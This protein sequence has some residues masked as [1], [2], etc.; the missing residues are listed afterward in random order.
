MKIPRMVKPENEII[1][2]E[3]ITTSDNNK[4]LILTNMNM[5]NI[6]LIS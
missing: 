4:N 5:M 3:K 2:L 6:I 1:H